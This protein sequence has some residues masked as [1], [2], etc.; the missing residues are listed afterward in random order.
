MNPTLLQP[1][2]M[3]IE[4]Y[5]DGRPIRAGDVIFFKPPGEAGAIVHRVVRITMAGLRTRGD[6]NGRD[7]EWIILP[8]QVRGRVSRAYRGRRQRAIP[9]GGVGLGWNYLLRG[10]QMVNR[11]AAPVLSPIYH[12][13]ANGGILARLIP[14][15]FA[16]RVVGFQHE[17]IAARKLFFFGTRDR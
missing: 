2:M 12:T 13:L 3:E 1:E 4:P 15:R 17:G 14:P 9:G 6:N 5:T 8:A 11:R 10:W 16:P 7:D